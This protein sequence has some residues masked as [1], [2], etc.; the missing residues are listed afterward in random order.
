VAL[1]STQAL[2]EM[3]LRKLPGVKGEGG[4]CMRLTISPPSVSQLLLR[5]CGILDTSHPYRPPR[6]VTGI[7]FYLFYLFY[8]S[9]ADSDHGVFFFT[10]FNITWNI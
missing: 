7:D 3:S 9:L 6:P 1:E 4:R 8:S 2:T 10:C 5:K